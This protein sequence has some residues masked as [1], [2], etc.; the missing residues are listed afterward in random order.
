[1]IDQYLHTLTLAE[2][3]YKLAMMVVYHAHF[4]DGFENKVVA[5]SYGPYSVD[6]AEL[7]LAGEDQA[8]ASS[9]LEASAIRLMAIIVDT[10]LEHAI[11][12]RFKAA[13]PLVLQTAF[14]ARVLRNAFAHDLFNPR[15]ELRDPRYS[16][17]FEVPGVIVVDTT[18]KDGQ[19][20]RWQDYG[21]PLALLKFLQH[22]RGVIQRVTA[23]VA[24]KPVNGVT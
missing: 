22:A 3:Q 1:M 7:R 18:G 9:A 17:R 6:G 10:A 5:F 13:E 12:N 21:G 8:R 14:I 15:W 23:Q 2:N 20:V 4:G 11:P 16:A 19:D 24:P